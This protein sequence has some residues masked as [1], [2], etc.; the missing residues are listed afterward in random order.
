MLDQ[1]LESVFGIEWEELSVQDAARVRSDFALASL[2]D[3]IGVSEYR[4]RI[5]AGNLASYAAC[6]AAADGIVDAGLGG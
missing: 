5:G 6:L 1:T 2:E 3:R 4:D